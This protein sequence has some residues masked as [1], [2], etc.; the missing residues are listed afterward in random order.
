MTGAEVKAIRDALGRLL[1]RHLSQ[2]D[3]G[4]ALGLAPDSAGRTV[5]SWEKAGP[6]GPAAVALAFMREATDIGTAH[7]GHGFSDGCKCTVLGMF[8][9]Q[10]AG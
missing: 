2:Q 6:S 8:E 5:R 7:G 3:L 9:I 1:G 10:S 4:V